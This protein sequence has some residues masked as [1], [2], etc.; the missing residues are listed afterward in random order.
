MSESVVTA[1]P[2]IEDT[3]MK[4][5]FKGII[6]SER[7]TEKGYDKLKQMCKNMAI[8][9]YE[10]FTSNSTVIEAMKDQYDPFEI[11]AIFSTTPFQK[12]KVLQ[13]L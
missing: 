3:S 1:N 10:Q 5:I 11:A 12:N 13:L 7:K 4:D 9:N 8:G 2:S 6:A